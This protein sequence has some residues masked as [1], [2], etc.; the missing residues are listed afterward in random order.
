M[1]LKNIN[2]ILVGTLIL[3]CAFNSIAQDTLKVQTFTF[4][5]IT[6]RTGNYEFPTQGKTWEKVLMQYTLKCDPRTTQDRFDCGEWDYLSYII[7]TDS[8]GTIDSVREQY[9]NFRIANLSPLSFAISENAYTHTRQ[10][11]EYRTVLDTLRSSDSVELSGSLK[12][13]SGEPIHS[14][15]VQYVYPAAELRNAGLQSGSVTSFALSSDN[16]TEPV[17][18]LQIHLFSRDSVRSFSQFIE[19]DGSPVFRGDLEL[20]GNNR[21]KINL[22]EPLVWDGSKDVILEFSQRRLDGAA[23]SSLEMYDAGMPC[24]IVAAGEGHYLE[25]PGDGY[26]EL[27][28]A[29]SVLEGL[30]SAISILF[31]AKGDA[32]LPA[33]TSVL[34]AFN[35]NDQRVL[36]IH[37]PWGNG[38]IYW[39]AG[40]KGS[41]DRIEKAAGV[42]LY[43]DKWN[44]WAFVKNA[45]TGSMKIYVNGVLWHSGT[46]N[47]RSMT[48]IRSLQFGRGITANQYK[49]KLDQLQFWSAELTAEQIGELMRRKPGMGTE[50]MD[51]LLFNFNFE[52]DEWN[53]P[54]E[55]TSTHDPEVSAYILGQHYIRPYAAQDYNDSVAVVREKPILTLYTEDR[56]IHTDS[57]L[58]SFE[59]DAP[60][61]TASLFEDANDPRVRTGFQYGFKAGWSY[62]YDADGN[63][64]DSA[65]IDTD[66]LLEQVLR[67]YYRKFE[68]INNI[69]IGRFITPYGIGLDLGPNGFRWVYDVTD[70]AHVLE[71]NVRLSAGN[72]QE[73]IDLRFDFIEG[74]PPRE[75][76]N[77]HYLSNRESRQYR[78]IADDTYF[79][80]DTVMLMED[81][82]TWKLITRITG[83]GHNGESGNGKIHCCEWADKEHYLDID[84]KR[85]IV[86]DIWQ[87][88]KCALNP[89]GDQG[90]NWAP[91]RAGWCPGAPVDDYVY[92]LT[93]YVNGDEIVID[94]GIEPVPSNNV[95][96]G[97]GNYVVSMHLVEYGPITHDLD[98]AIKDIISPNSWEFYR[99]INPTCAQPKIVLQ[100]K[101]KEPLVGAFLVYGVEGGNPISFYW[102]GNLG[103]MEEE[104]ID[105]PYAIWDYAGGNGKGMFYAD[106]QLA[107]GKVDEYAANNKVRV[108]YEQP[109]VLPGNIEVM[110]RN[111]DIQDADLRIWNDRG[112]LVYSKIDAPAKVLNRETV[113]FDPGCYKLEV[114]T[115]NG[116]G[117]SYP[118][119]PEVGAGFLRL[120]QTDGIM[121]VAFNPDFGKRLTYYFTVG[122]ALSEGQILET[123]RLTELY[124]NP[125]NGV[126]YLN[127]LSHEMLKYQVFDLQGRQLCS[128]ELETQNMAAIDL[129][130]EAAGLYML[131]TMGSDNAEFSRLLKH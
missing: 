88:D 116:F 52:N 3:L 20:T 21:T 79:K 49:G 93:D 110:Y 40:D 58:R 87:N 5:D 19:N 86:W 27:A 1:Q 48:G 95:G 71:G 121:N 82:S 32:S 119:I 125:S 41:Y 62:T 22:S 123:S 91:P 37:L 130:G 80:A 51:Q 35:A 98:A 75:V 68:V 12:S 104:V 53:E 31:W 30:D 70:Y 28:K 115:E 63:P 76:K 131:R 117:L 72:Q 55:I 100:N 85:E 106:V 8:T 6:K 124:P 23:G 47:T 7:V 16:F 11:F 54:Y 39:D 94:Y 90:G 24:G 17:T 36:N 112:D 25:L 66:V 26:L 10:Y 101:G 108:A 43:K 99:Q 122:Y 114:E 120:R 60:A 59:E 65:A 126:F 69:E 57:T 74:T 18:N 2:R 56:V 14:Y 113:N 102:E 107:N 4:E 77:I 64:I 109:P 105:L 83:H 81:A 111:N 45:R 46:G 67:D 78:F 103:F 97:N 50:P 33:N 44:H 15:R 84:G 92:E 127:N 129:S 34:E 61:Y 29:D 9:P 128:G 118:L 73:L 38:N 13:V 42:G 89:V 96:Q